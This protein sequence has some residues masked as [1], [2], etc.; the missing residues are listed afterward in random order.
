MTVYVL[1]KNGRFEGVYR[2]YEAAQERISQMPFFS[3]FPAEYE[4]LEEILR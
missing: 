2:S 4:I 1:F 3:D